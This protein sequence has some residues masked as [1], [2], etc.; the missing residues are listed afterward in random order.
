MTLHI[1]RR[2]F[3]NGTVAGVGAAGFA[4]ALS[5]AREARAQKV[6]LTGVMFGGPWIESAKG[7]TARQTAVD[8]KWELH[9]GGTAAIVPKILAAMPNPIYDFVI[10]FD[11]IYHM[12]MNADLPEPVTLDDVP[13][14]KDVPEDYFYKNSKGQIVNIPASITATFFGYRKDI[15]PF[16]IKTMNDLLDPRLKGKVCVRDATYGLNGNLA[17]YAVANGGSVTSLEPGWEF[18]KT[19]AKSGNIA[20]FAKSDSD[21]INS[22]SSGEAVAGFGNLGQWSKIGTNFPC[23]FLIRDKK[24]APGFQA[25]LFQEGFMILKTSQKKKEAKQFLNFF[26][27]P[28]NSGTYNAP[29]NSAPPNSKSPVTEVAKKIVF[30]RKEERDRFC[31]LYDWKHLSDQGKAGIERFEKEIV[32]LA[33]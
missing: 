12:F 16:P 22:L 25:G 5:F 27:N 3:L 7:I 24:D 31:L 9:T 26:L 30:P 32:P 29:L 21:F 8:V 4:S 14:L 28:E 33:R 19:F 18:L 2:R 15:C 1:S 6:A 13:N 23:E 20:R 10:L 11:P 17:H